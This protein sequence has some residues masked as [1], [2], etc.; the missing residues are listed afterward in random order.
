MTQIIHIVLLTVLGG[1]VSAS[2]AAIFL[3]LSSQWRTRLLP[4]LISFATGALLAAALLALLPEA[5]DAVAGEWESI[6]LTLLIGLL[7][8]FVLEKLLLWRHCHADHCE[9]HAPTDQHRAA[10]AGGLILVG[11]GLHNFLDGLLIAGAYLVEP[12]LGIATAIAV[13]AH[14]IPQ[15]IGDLAILLEGGY[16]RRRA[17]V[18]NLLVNALTVVGG[19]L[20]VV[21]LRST[22]DWL[23]YVITLAAAGLLYIAIA[24]LIPSL[25]RRTDPK[26][27]VAQVLLIIAGIAVIMLTHEWL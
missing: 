25:H 6:G 8:F 11:D 1:V 10:T 20:G 26:T 19:V 24:D 16:S 18:W 4:H 2:V 22:P 3:L 27:M 21:V 23:P 14:E 7:I 5:L 9:V 15:E 12:G 13:F 17:L